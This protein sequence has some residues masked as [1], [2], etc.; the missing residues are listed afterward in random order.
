M[1]Y[2]SDE[3]ITNGTI[4][5]AVEEKD[6]IRVSPLLVIANVQ[7]NETAKFN[8]KVYAMAAGR[9]H[10]NLNISSTNLRYS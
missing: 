4:D 8:I 7:E 5:I 9:A 6:L 1:E 10:V 3:Y 2:F